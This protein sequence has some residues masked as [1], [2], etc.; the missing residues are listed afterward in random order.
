VTRG[1]GPWSSWVILAFGV[2]R[3]R[4]RRGQR[5]AHLRIAFEAIGERQIATNAGFLPGLGNDK[6]P[7]DSPV[8]VRPKGRTQAPNNQKRGEFMLVKRRW[9]SETGYNKGELGAVGNAEWTGV[10]LSALLE[11]AGLEEDAC[12]IVLE[13]PDR[14]VP[15]EGAIPPGPI[16]VARSLPRA[17]ALRLVRGVKMESMLRKG[18]KLCPFRP[19]SFVDPLK[20][21]SGDFR[22]THPRRILHHEHQN[23]K[24]N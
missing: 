6:R 22:I 8:G 21:R 14:G 24:T 11:H 20:G 17:K 7:D 10:P 2:R 5:N 4:S 9:V 18:L 19:V 16:S 13:G 1:W 3:G 15:K 23:R 12:E